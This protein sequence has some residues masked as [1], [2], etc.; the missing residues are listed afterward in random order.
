[1]GNRGFTLIELMIVV[2]LI[3]IL[4][5]IAYPSYQQYV[6]KSKRTEAK[7]ALMDLAQNQ[8]KFRGNCLSYATALSNAGTTCNVSGPTYQIEDSGADGSGI[9]TTPD[10]NYSVRIV[11]GNSQGYEIRA[12]ANGAQQNDTGCTTMKITVNA[13][14]PDGLKEP[15]DCW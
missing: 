4:A 12:D 8:E 5:A 11:S 9:I 1:M 10:G 15:V 3:G 7:A 6:L 14:N 13:A 2:A